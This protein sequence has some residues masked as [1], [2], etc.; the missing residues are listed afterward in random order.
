MISSLKVGNEKEKVLTSKS[1]SFC[2]VTFVKNCDLEMHLMEVHNKVKK[3]KVQQGLCFGME[4]GGLVT[5]TWK[6]TLLMLNT[7][8]FWDHYIQLP[9]NRL[10][11]AHL[12]FIR[13]FNFM[14]CRSVP[15]KVGRL[16]IV[17][18]WMVG[19]LMRFCDSEPNPKPKQDLYISNFGTMLLH[20]LSLLSSRWSARAIQVYINLLNISFYSN[21]FPLFILKKHSPKSLSENSPV[22]V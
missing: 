16:K 13:Q 5:N 6:C 15:H 20:N 4:V 11:S 22:K 17:R 9:T 2:D 12:Y 7:V 14:R 10:F 18:I 1:C 3:W 19:R 21:I 8:I